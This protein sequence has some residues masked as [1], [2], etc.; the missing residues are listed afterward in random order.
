M[1]VPLRTIRDLAPRGAGTPADSLAVLLP[2]AYDTPED[3]LREGFVSAVRE[4]QVPVDL[5]LVD[6]HLAY[7]G[8]RT[9]VDRLRQD[10]VLPARQAG[11]RQIW[12][13]GISLGGMGALAYAMDHGSEVD[14][15]FLLAPYLGTRGVQKEIAAAGGLRRWQPDATAGDDE[16]ER[17]LWRWLAGRANASGEAQPP[18]WQGYGRDDRFAP[19]HRL[20]A[21]A[22]PA[23]HSQELPGSHDWTAWR[24]LWAAFLERGILA[25][26]AA[27]PSTTP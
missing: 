13:V 25:A 16:D 4:R 6:A 18:I 8:D 20:L 14:G 10:I 11:Y 19:A 3:L 17:R 22:L 27:A 26:P 24:A 1:S 21:T 9:V 7:Y 15:L 12:L 2:G 23:A 5:Q